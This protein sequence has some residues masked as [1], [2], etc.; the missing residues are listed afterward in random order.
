MR[1]IAGL[2]RGYRLKA[3]KGTDTRPTSDRVKEAIFNVLSSKVINSKVLDMFAGTGGMGI[4]ALSRGANKAVF[5]EKR[6]QTWIVL[7]ENLVHTGLF[8]SSEIYLS[9]FSHVL[10]R[11]EDRF[12]LVFLDPP[13]GKGYIQPACLLIMKHVLLNSGGIIVVE[14]ASKE[15][16]LP[17]LANVNLV[18]E[19][20]YGDTAVLYYQFS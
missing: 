6:R 10:P 7:K 18:K 14:T 20:I 1:V 8:A 17:E 4:E 16:E 15:K 2:A 9:D 13:Y 5:V 11:L 3:P 12:D 19:S